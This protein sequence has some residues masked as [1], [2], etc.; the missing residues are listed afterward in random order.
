MRLDVYHGEDLVASFEYGRRPSYYGAQGRRVKDLLARPHYV[1]SLWTGEILR[2]ATAD[3]PEWW[4]S[5]ITSAGLAAE[6]FR[7]QF[8]LTLTGLPAC[9]PLAPEGRAGTPLPRHRASL[10]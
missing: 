10:A 4:V 1:R 6:G 9:E 2:S 7:L 5:N 3:T 8:T